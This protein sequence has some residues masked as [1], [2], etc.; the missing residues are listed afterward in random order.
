VT[1]LAARPAS[2]ADEATAPPVDVLEVS[3]FIDRPVA[4]SI[5]RAI[6]RANSDGAQALVLQL[7]SLR[8]TVSRERMAELARTIAARRFRSPSG[9]APPALEA[10]G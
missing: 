9:S 10:T 7:S 4:D 1:S 8:A 5:E 6:A 2:A 3:G